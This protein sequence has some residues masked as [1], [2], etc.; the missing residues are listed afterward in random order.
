M[1]QL[2]FTLII[3]DVIGIIAIYLVYSGKIP[4]LSSGFVPFYKYT[5]PGIWWF[6][7]IFLL[8]Y[9]LLLVGFTIKILISEFL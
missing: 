4:A 2:L 6:L 3:M 1:D 5:N 7:F 8:V 9:V